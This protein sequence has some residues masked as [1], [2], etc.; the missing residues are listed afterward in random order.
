MNDNKRLS[1]S[2]QPSISLEKLRLK[3]S[4]RTTFKLPKDTINLLGLIA[5][6][7][8]I[9]QKSLLDQLTEDREQLNRLAQTADQKNDKNTNRYPKTYVISRNSLQSINEVAKQQKVPRDVLVEFS[10]K[11]LVP[12]IENEIEKHGERKKIFKGMRDYLKE[13]EKLRQRV[14]ETLGESDEMFDMI[15][16]Q[17]KLA[18]KNIIRSSTIIEKGSPM[19]DW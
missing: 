5:G 10:I 14:K 12:V 17:V 16:R 18:Q 13:G 1:H 4:V 8:G 19:E 3:Q 11:R 2:V 7:L 15:D 6:Q 9:K